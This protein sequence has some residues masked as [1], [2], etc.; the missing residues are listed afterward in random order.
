MVPRTLNLAFQDASLE[1]FLRDFGIA[2]TR[3]PDDFRFIPEIYR[4]G[5]GGI[6]ADIS[7]CF[8]GGYLVVPRTVNLA[9]QAAPSRCFLRNFGIVFTLLSDD[10]RIISEIYRRGIMRVEKGVYRGISVVVPWWFPGP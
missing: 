10:S 7:G 1:R 4:R 5:V 6:Y 2:F 9:F 8:G 3:L